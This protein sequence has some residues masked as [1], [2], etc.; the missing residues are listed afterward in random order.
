MAHFEFAG[1][2]LPAADAIADSRLFG[3]ALSLAEVR[4][5]RPGEYYFVINASEPQK[6]HW[7]S[8]RSRKRDWRLR[9]D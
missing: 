3:S 9:V 4:K 5:Q 2:K 7:Q 1:R 6:G 8:W